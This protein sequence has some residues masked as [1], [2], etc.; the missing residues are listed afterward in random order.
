MQAPM[1]PGPWFRPSNGSTPSRSRILAPAV[2]RVWLVAAQ[3]PQL[4]FGKSRSI[5]AGAVLVV[6]DLLL[7]IASHW[8]R[9]DY[10]DGSQ[11]AAS[12]LSSA[13][14]GLQLRR[15]QT[16][17]LP[18]LLSARCGEVSVTPAM[19]AADVEQGSRDRSLASQRGRRCSTPQA[20]TPA[21]LPRR[22]EPSSEF[23]DGLMVVMSDL[24]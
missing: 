4:K 23:A 10:A 24:G 13:P 14:L 22:M 8:G 3:I 12:S 19:L 15:E 6:G 5:V 2:R 20:V 16:E 9:F 11:R 21:P 18:S 1:A 7:I 17:V